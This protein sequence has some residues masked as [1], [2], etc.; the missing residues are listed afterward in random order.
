MSEIKNA[1]VI[2][3]IASIAEMGRDIVYVYKSGK[4][5]Q[6]EIKKG[7]RTASSLQ[8]IDG[9]QSGDTLII[10]GVMQLRDGMDVVINK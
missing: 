1:I 8:V 7:M 9:L 4:A 5:H 3:A 6:V 10:S 2:P